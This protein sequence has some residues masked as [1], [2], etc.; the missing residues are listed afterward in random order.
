MASIETVSCAQCG[1]DVPAVTRGKPRRF[2]SINCGKQFGNRKADWGSIEC[3]SCGANFSERLR[4]GR[5]PTRCPSCRPV[6][7]NKLCLNCGSGVPR[8]RMRSPFCT[9]TCRREHLGVLSWD[10]RK[11]LE[12]ASARRADCAHC[13]KN[14]HAKASKKGQPQKFCSNKCKW[15]AKR[16]YASKR[17]AR[18]AWR[19]A[20]GIKPRE[21]KLPSAP[22][23]KACRDC[24]DVVAKWAQ[25]CEP[26]RLKAKSARKQMAKHSPSVRASRSARRARYRIRLR[27]ATVERFD[28]FDVFE[29]DGWRCHMCGIKTPKRLRGTY[30]DNA[31][32]LDHI[33]PLAAGGDH[34]RRN[35]ACSCRKCNIAKSDKPLGQLRLVA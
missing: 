15:E 20:Q 32:E 11:A 23:E 2:C 24:G 18:E 35:T 8:A 29:R 33:V 13:G 30:E 25:R 17:E 6:P 27:Q 19:R 10:E 4:Q 16:K 28:P 3:V 7:V 14:F 9:D 31:P 1:G 26:C 5:R 21:I 12:R 22:V 34:S